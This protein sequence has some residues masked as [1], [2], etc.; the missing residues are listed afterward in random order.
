[1]HNLVAGPGHQV[2]ADLGAGQLGIDR[3]AGVAQ[4]ADGGPQ[5]E[6]LRPADV[7]TVDLQPDGRDVLVGGGRVEA[8]DQSGQR[9]FHFAEQARRAGR[10]GIVA[11]E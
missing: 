10:F 8:A 6:R 11:A 3:F 2:L 7:Q 4:P 5:L 9:R 1:M